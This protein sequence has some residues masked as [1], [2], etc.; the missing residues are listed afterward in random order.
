MNILD[1]TRSYEEWM[2]RQI[3]VVKKDLATKHERMADSAFVFLRGTFYRWIQ[4]WPSVCAALAEA[5]TVPSIGDLH[6]ENF[7]TWRDGEGRLIWGVND[8]DEACEVPYPNDLVRLAT[9]AAL[10]A[11]Q[12]RMHLRLRDI[13]DAIADGYLQALNAHG[14]PFVLAEKRRWLRAIALNRLKDPV[15]Y[16]PKFD[17]LRTPRYPVPHVVLRAALPEPRLPYRALARTAGVGS[18]GRP[19]IVAVAEWR[20]A[21]IAR[22]A[23][24]R[25]ASAAVWA[26]GR[27]AVGVDSG[28]LL[29]R[30][31]RTPD[32]FL[33]FHP[34]WIVRRLA[35]DCSRIEL[36]DMPRERD[37]ERLLSAM[38][39]E[40]A[41]IH[42]GRNPS[43][44]LAD[45]KTRPRRWLW[46]AAAAMSDAVD[47]DHRRWVR[48]Q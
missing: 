48:Q 41:N 21:R 30:A 29:A 15:V 5:P 42:L 2:H 1:A 22:E 13:C 34:K 16:W 12:E 11:R 37:E 43:P 10:A 18:L 26:T 4:L 14:R 31:A 44:I 28:A 8:A 27:P 32:P 39:A 38:G 23:K 47:K 45:L 36:D 25:L 6:V 40:V 3:P 19:R 33:T 35:P 24:A 17:T 20:G 46:D 9:S 7:G